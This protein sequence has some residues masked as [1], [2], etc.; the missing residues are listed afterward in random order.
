[1]KEQNTQPLQKIAIVALI[2]PISILITVIG[3]GLIINSQKNILGGVIGVGELSS[4]VSLIIG[5]SLIVVGVILFFITHRKGRII[6][7]PSFDK[8]IKKLKGQRRQ[9]VEDAVK[10][11]GTGLGGEEKLRHLPGYSI[12]VSNIGRVRYNRESSGDVRLK[13]YEAKHEYDAA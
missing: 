9:E 13:K 12:R 7:D 4:N 3:A 8:S 2:K 10:K 11:I 1:M 5:L 6:R